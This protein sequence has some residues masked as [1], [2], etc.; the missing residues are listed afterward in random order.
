MAEA[1]L[2]ALDLVL[3]TYCCWIIVRVSRRPHVQ[4][5]DFGLFAF[6]EDRKDPGQ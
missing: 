4:T 6:K 3:V 1:A 2:L 5:S